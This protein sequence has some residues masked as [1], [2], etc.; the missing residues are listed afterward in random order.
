MK[1]FKRKKHPKLNKRSFILLVVILILFLIMFYFTKVNAKTNFAVVSGV[2]WEDSN[3]NGTKDDGEVVLAGIDVYLCD[4]NGNVMRTTSGDEVKTQTDSNGYY[5]FEANLGS[6]DKYSI[7]FSYSGL[8]YQ[9]VS[10]VKQGLT[11]DINSFL[12]KVNIVWNFPKTS[13]GKEYTYQ[14][15]MNQ[16]NISNKEEILLQYDNSA[17]Y[18]DNTN[19]SQGNLI[20]T[21]M[22]E[23]G[24][25]N[26]INQK[27]I[28]FIYLDNTN[29]P[30]RDDFLNK[31]K[32]IQNTIDDNEYKIIIGFSTDYTD[33]SFKNEVKNTQSS[34]IKVIENE[35]QF[36]T[37]VVEYL[38]GRAK[39]ELENPFGTEDESKREW[40]QNTYP[41]LSASERQTYRQNGTTNITA[42]SYP[43]ETDG[44]LTYISIGLKHLVNS[45]GERNGNDVTANDTGDKLVVGS[46]Y[47]QEDGSK[48]TNAPIKVELFKQVQTKEEYD[49]R[50]ANGAY[51][52]I[53]QNPNEGYYGKVLVGNPSQN[54]VVDD[55]GNYSIAYSEM[56]TYM[57]RFTY[58]HN[59]ATQAQD[60]NG[61]KCM[62]PEGAVG[63]TRN[64]DSRQNNATEN[65]ERRNEINQYFLSDEDGDGF[66][67]INNY[68]T[69]LKQLNMNELIEKTQMVATTD[70][71]Q[72][73]WYIDDDGI[74]PD[75]SEPPP[76]MYANLVLKRREQVDFKITNEVEALQLTLSDGSIEKDMR[77]SKDKN[78]S[79]DPVYMQLDDEYLHGATLKV[80]YMITIKNTGDLP[81]TSM[82]IMDYLDHEYKH[83]QYSPEEVML[84][85]NKKNRDYGWNYLTNFEIAEGANDHN[86]QNAMQKDQI[87][88]EYVQKE[89]LNPGE[90]K[91]LRLVAS[92]AISKRDPEYN[93]GNAV[94]VISYTN[95]K[96]RVH[97]N[98]LQ[99]QSVFTVG[100]LK[101]TESASNASESDQAF[102]QEIVITKPTGIKEE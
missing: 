5:Q 7:K 67:G 27:S 73:Y 66:A 97:E 57:V 85:E 38:A 89:T 52:E 3:E 16:F 71:F 62:V 8:D 48:V 99:R 84:T 19:I 29:P 41:A 75:E 54:K 46:V 92:V 74:D 96:G 47:W 45:E 22:T 69:R 37:A 81:I 33:E 51:G 98:S 17:I 10:I 23:V 88:L 86:F 21:D 28:F 82:R 95:D 30:A 12:T 15:R 64:Q 40:L 72:I 6:Y 1:S 80:Q 56:G 9:M 18:R 93:Y 4:A 91:V 13:A 31:L 24:S 76:T 90:E 44:K 49:Q 36:E 79:L 70:W 77:K 101:P 55:N 14:A 42:T 68:K 2:A 39:E 94:E 83:L 60:V 65:I 78:L 87:Y 59:S 61:E 35:Q 25:L 58:G 53:N 102:A 11:Y 20:Y 100:N 26:L 63:V 43:I 32:Q 34:R 50:V